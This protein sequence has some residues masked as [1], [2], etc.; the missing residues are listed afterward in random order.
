MFEN[1]EYCKP[2]KTLI[3]VKFTIYIKCIKPSDFCLAVT[4]T[5]KTHN[6]FSALKA[7]LI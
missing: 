6:K 3:I 4:A 5:Y 7:N 2:Y 1:I